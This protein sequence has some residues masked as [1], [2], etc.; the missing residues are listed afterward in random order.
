MANHYFRVT[1]KYY[2]PGMYTAVL[3]MIPGIYSI[4][5]L[6]R[7]R[8]RRDGSVRRDSRTE[9]IELLRQSLV[10]VALVV[11]D[12]DEAIAFFC[13][14]APLH[15]RRGHGPARAEQALGGRGAA[16]LLRYH[17]PPRARHE[18]RTDVGDRK[19]DRREGVPLPRHR[20]L[21]ARLRTMR[22]AGVRFVRDP[23]EA[24]YGTVAVFEDLYGNR[25]DL[26]QLKA[27]R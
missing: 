20:R 15:A 2:F 25:W 19:S 18:P 27:S 12:Y 3:P 22:A 23:K 16:G 17:A 7:N 5:W 21:L 10:H 24:P 11:R 14:K 13:R 26:V 1:G 6:F 4:V 8:H 9:R